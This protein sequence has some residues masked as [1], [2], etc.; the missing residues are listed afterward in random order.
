MA[1]S[2][3]GENLTSSACCDNFYLLLGG[4]NGE[5]YNMLLLKKIISN[6]KLPLFLNLNFAIYSHKTYTSLSSTI[7]SKKSKGATYRIK[8]VLGCQ[9]PM[10]WL[11]HKVRADG[12]QTIKQETS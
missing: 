7:S 8:S 5:R 4:A 1:F 9:K 6:P 10:L 2:S 3:W 12:I 11:H